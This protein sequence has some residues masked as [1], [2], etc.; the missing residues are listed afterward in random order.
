MDAVSLYM[1]FIHLAT[2]KAT[3]WNQIP[4]WFLMVVVNLTAIA[5]IRV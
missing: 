2:V 5:V 1:I 3:C 4:N